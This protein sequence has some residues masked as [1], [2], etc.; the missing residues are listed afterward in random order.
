MSMP[1][2]AISAAALL[3]L[4]ASVASA[5]TPQNIDPGMIIHKR[6]ELTSPI[7]AGSYYFSDHKDRQ[8]GSCGV[9][10]R[11]LERQPGCVAFE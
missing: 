2:K 8:A 1:L 9:N 4:G 7:S 3:V 11:G 5:H 6:S 10:S